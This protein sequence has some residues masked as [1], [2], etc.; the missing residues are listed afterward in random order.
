MAGCHGSAMIPTRLLG[1]STSGHTDWATFLR[2][3]VQKE[4]VMRAQLLII[5]LKKLTH[6]GSPRGARFA[7]NIADIQYFMYLTGIR[8]SGAYPG[9]M[10]LIV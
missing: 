10:Y 9:C 2:L 3:G 6:L 1:R 8:G 5:M 4:M 7:L